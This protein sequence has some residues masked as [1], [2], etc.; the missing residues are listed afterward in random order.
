MYD[1]LRPILI[2]SQFITRKYTYFHEEFQL[3]SLE[4][5]TITFSIE[6]QN[7]FHSGSKYKPFLP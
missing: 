5:N 3:N 4:Q 2:C 6:L 7:N 1:I